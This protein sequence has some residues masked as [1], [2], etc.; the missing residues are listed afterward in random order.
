MRHGFSRESSRISEVSHAHLF[1][2][3]GLSKIGFIDRFFLFESRQERLLEGR[4]ALQSGSFVVTRRGWCLLEAVN[5]ADTNRAQH[6]Q[7]PCVHRFTT[8]YNWF[9]ACLFDL[10][11]WNQLFFYLWCDCI[12][13]FF[14][15]DLFGNSSIGSSQRHVFILETFKMEDVRWQRPGN[16]IGKR[17]KFDNHVCQLATTTRNTHPTIIWMT[18]LRTSEANAPP[19]L[20]KPS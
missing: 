12:A 11:V 10:R 7:R 15:K 1:W 8:F 13:T 19:A 20:D 16:Y 3:S 14:T 9:M 18:H 2:Y 4:K 6:Q 5:G 17:N